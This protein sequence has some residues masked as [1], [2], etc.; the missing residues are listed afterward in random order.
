VVTALAQDWAGQL[1]IGTTKGIVTYKDGLLV[2]HENDGFPTSQILSIRVTRDGSVWIGARGSGLLRYR[3]GEFRT[4]GAPEGLPSKYVQAIYEDKNSTLW[5]GTLDQGVGRFTNEQF[6]FATTAA[7]GI[8]QKPV[9]S[10]LEDREGNLW[11][12]SKKGL[13]A[14]SVGKAV[15]FTTAHGLFADNIRTVTGASNGSVGSAP[16]G[17]RRSTAITTGQTTVSRANGHDDAEHA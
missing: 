2:R 3:S 16:A 13:T 12:G 1:W 10:F 14:V 7:I 8:G 9:S 5:I 4:Y 17:C 6:D 15:T 11:I